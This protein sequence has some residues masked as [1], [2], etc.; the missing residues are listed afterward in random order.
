MS[1]TTHGSKGGSSNRRGFLSGS[2]ALAAGL[3]ARA[4]KASGRTPLQSA[5]SRIRELGLELPDPPSPI[6]VYVPAVITGNLLFVSGHGPAAIEGVK[7]GKVGQDLTIEEGKLAARA[8][9]LRILSTMRDRLGSLDRVVRLVRSFGMVNAVPDFTEQPQVI[10]GY[11]ELMVE[12]FGET[13]GKGARAAVGM[14][15]LPSN[16]AVEIESIWEIRE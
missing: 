6:A 3:L 12:V 13:N 9:G 15:S 14:G 5:E 16:I 10:N 8:T 11:S 7:P 4:G 2:V 1:K